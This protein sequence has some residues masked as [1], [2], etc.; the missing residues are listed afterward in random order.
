MEAKLWRSSAHQIHKDFGFVWSHKT[1]DLTKNENLIR[2][3]K[4]LCSQC[5]GEPEDSPKRKAGEVI[6]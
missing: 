1:Q 5:K 3:P 4:G 2:D 6:E